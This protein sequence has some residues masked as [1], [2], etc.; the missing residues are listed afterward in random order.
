MDLLSVLREVNTWP[1]EDRVRLVHEVWDQL[2]DQGVEQDLPDELKAEL[3]RR[4]AADD[5]DPD[6]LVPWE[7][8][9]AAALLRARS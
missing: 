6:D 3:D 2:V 4:L 7:E 8:A 5:A 1:L 9:K